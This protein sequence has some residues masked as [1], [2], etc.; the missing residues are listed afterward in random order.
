MARTVFTH[1]GRPVDLRTA[2]NENLSEEFDN[3]MTRVLAGCGQD[4]VPLGRVGAAEVEQ[5]VLNV[6]RDFCFVGRQSRAADDTVKLQQY[7]GLPEDPLAVDNVTP[8]LDARAQT[9]MAALDWGGANQRNNADQM[10]V[11]RLEDEGLLSRVLK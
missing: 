3:V 5:A 11:E 8:P 2:F 4:Q 7:L 6:R 9:L 10:L 1:E